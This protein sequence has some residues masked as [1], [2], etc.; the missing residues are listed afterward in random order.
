MWS[1][2]HTDIVQ[3]MNDSPTFQKSFPIFDAFFKIAEMYALI[4]QLRLL[5]L[6]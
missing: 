4:K 1:M 3:P 5:I 6:N 2:Q